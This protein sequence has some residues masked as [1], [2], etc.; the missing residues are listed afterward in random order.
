MAFINRDSVHSWN[1]PDKATVP[2][3]KATSTVP[4]NNFS[5]NIDNDLT[6]LPVALPSGPIFAWSLVIKN[7][8]H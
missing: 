3:G 2:A 5:P 8:K 1:P 4:T 6:V 7:D